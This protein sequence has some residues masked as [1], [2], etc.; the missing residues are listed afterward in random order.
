[1]NKL[2]LQL[3]ALAIVLPLFSWLRYNP[4]TDWWSDAGCMFLIALALVSGLLF[5][6]SKE[7]LTAWPPALFLALGWLLIAILLPSGK[8][9][10]GFVPVLKVA[11]FVVMAFA[12]GTVAFRA[13]Q[14]LGREQ[15]VITLA[16]TI[17]LGA[18]LQ[19][20]IGF[21]QATGWVSLAHGYFF[22][23]PASPGPMTPI[24]NIG[25]RNLFAH[26]LGWGMVAS[27]YL[28]AARR[29]H[30]AVWLPMMALLA[31][32][33]AWSGSR[34]VLAYSAGFIV[35]A[36][37]WRFRAKDDEAVRRLVWSAIA[38]IVLIALT[39]LFNH[40]LVAVIHTS[41]TGLQPV[42]GAER[43]L[44]DGFGARRRIEWSKAWQVLQ[45]Y[46]LFGTG[47]GGFAWQSVWYEAYGGYPKVVESTLFTHAHS[48]IF[49]L[50]AETGLV[51]LI[52]AL[53]ALLWCLL[54]YLNKREATAEN[55]LLISLAMITLGHSLFE[56]PLWYMPFLTGLAVILCLSP[57]KPIALAIRPVMRSSIALFVSIAALGYCI[58]GVPTFWR[59]V[60]WLVPSQVTEENSYRMHQL[61]ALR[62]NPLWVSEVDQVLSNY[63][64]PSRQQLPIQLAMFEEMVRYR[65]YFET[66]V[67]LAMLE[68]LDKQPGKAQA[69]MAMALA[70]FPDLAEKGRQMLSVY[71]ELEYVPLENMAE[72]VLTV[73]RQGGA[74]AA[75]SA[76]STAE[77]RQALF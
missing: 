8:N 53:A 39:Q 22:F 64:F 51:G 26:F 72:K 9:L 7:F 15:V 25:Q 17:L 35:L 65:P 31:L 66:L 28:W 29:L 67:K 73:Y 38:A 27:C 3:L 57:A 11:A 18:L 5:N 32:L 23:N 48:L 56:Y 30:G 37:I 63:L 52:G 62:Q 58:N 46:P 76:V 68:A 2:P 1:M 54:P 21:A 10:A 45:A 41:G 69:T 12:G 50:M 49:Q 16:W 20:I 75:A 34:L 42:S 33:M 43:L 24:G 59:L 19:A 13:T 74:A 61:I 55:L 14:G 71:P 36:G 4:L 77:Y 44:E 6:R 40:A 47:F 60:H 70:A